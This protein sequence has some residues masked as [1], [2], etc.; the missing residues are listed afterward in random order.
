[1]KQQRRSS[2]SGSVALLVQVP[3][4]V[5]HARELTPMRELVP[6]RLQGGDTA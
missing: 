4:L 3:I 6:A 5:W 2:D 1:M